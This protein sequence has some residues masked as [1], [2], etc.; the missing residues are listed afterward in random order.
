MCVYHLGMSSLD[1]G[2][3]IEC[4]RLSDLRVSLV[5][6]CTSLRRTVIYLQPYLA[7]NLPCLSKALWSAHCDNHARDPRQELMPAKMSFDT[8]SNYLWLNKLL[9]RDRPDLDLMTL[10]VRFQKRI[11]LTNTRFSLRFTAVLVLV[12]FEIIE[13]TEHKNVRNYCIAYRQW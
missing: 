13:L 7:K 12:N 1:D 3:L 8:I 9:Y 2:L 6:L 4:K 5:C 10:L 11:R